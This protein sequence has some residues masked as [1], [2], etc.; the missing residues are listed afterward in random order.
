MD[1]D[2]ALM[3]VMVAE[4]SRGEIASLIPIMKEHCSKDQYEE[5]VHSMATVIYD[6]GEEIMEKVY[7]LNPSVR[8]TYK[9]NWDKFGRAYY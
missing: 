9:R 2:L 1:E 6:I 3:I 7:A 8:V 5:I 4:R